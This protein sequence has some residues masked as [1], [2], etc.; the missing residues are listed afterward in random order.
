MKKLDIILDSDGVLADTHTLILDKY[1][2]E[3]GD[4]LTIEHITDWNLEKFTKPGSDIL[5]YFSKR[6]FFMQPDPCPGAVEVVNELCADGHNIYVATSSPKEGYEDKELW[7]RRHFPK[8]PKRNITMIH[9]K[10]L[11]TGDIL[12]D[13]GL[14]NLRPT[15]CRH[16]IVMDQPWNRKDANGLVRVLDMWDFYST[17][18]LI[19]NGCSYE[20]LLEKKG[21]MKCAI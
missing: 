6:G 13:D 14:H 11:L 3:Y 18:L 16:P 7:I 19:A 17:V 1:N 5:K 8:I 12:L 20:E 2:W 4:N 15:N 10:H 9:T 21:E